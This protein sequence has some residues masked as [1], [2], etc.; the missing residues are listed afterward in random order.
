MRSSTSHHEKSD[1]DSERESDEPLIKA[2][3]LG[4]RDA[5]RRLYEQNGAKVHRLMLRMVGQQDAVDLTQQTFLQVFRKI[6]QFSGKSEFATWLYRVAVNEAL[7]HRRRKQSRPSQP[8]QF[9]PANE[10]N[11]TDGYEKKEAIEHALGKIEPE[12]RAIFLL[13]EIDQLS[14]AQLSDVL[15]IPA[16]TVASRLNRARRE[17]RE[18]LSGPDAR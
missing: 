8:L 4:D 13:R 17:L 1:N 10:T 7:Q 9:E 14:Y 11:D 12:L 15:E 3:Q 2:C 5:Q 18:V 6:H 16:G